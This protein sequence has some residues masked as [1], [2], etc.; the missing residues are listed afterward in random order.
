MKPF[1]PL[2]PF[3]PPKSFDLARKLESTK[4]TDDSIATQNSDGPQTIGNLIENTKD[5]NDKE[6]T[7]KAETVQEPE[8]CVTPAITLTDSSPAHHE[9]QIQP[10]SSYTKPSTDS[11]NVQSQNVH[12][13]FESLSKT[14]NIYQSFEQ[15]PPLDY[16][17]HQ[18][19]TNWY[20]Q[21]T[22]YNAYV[23]QSF[24]NPPAE[25]YTQNYNS[26]VKP[27]GSPKEH[28][29]EIKEERIKNSLKEI[30]SDLDTYAEKD[31]GE[32][33]EER[34]LE[35]ASVRS[36]E[37]VLENSSVLHQVFLLKSNVF[38]FQNSSINIFNI[39]GHWMRYFRT[40]K[41]FRN[42]YKK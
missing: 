22:D 26:T 31:L 10:E 38:T 30:I 29:A 11:F 33:R 13:P 18:P 20:N 16:S 1:E 32:S 6:P 21:K 17:F 2:E 36:Y 23:P 15:L 7:P 41:I 9:V 24:Y 34:K 42:E 28:K 19:Q 5:R 40:F 4:I 12:P 14:Q 8:R 39:V 35:N 3:E 27:F 25:I 37:S